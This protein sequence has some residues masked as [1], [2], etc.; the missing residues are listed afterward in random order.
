MILQHTNCSHFG[1]S[2][3]LMTTVSSDDETMQVTFR[4][5][6]WLHERLHDRAARDFRSVNMTAFLILS[7]ATEK[8]ALDKAMPNVYESEGH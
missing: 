4:F 8:D 6:R 3:I 5:P 1:A 7:M 2:V